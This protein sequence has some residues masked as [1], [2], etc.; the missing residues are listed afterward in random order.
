[1]IWAFIGGCVFGSVFTIFAMACGIAVGRA[2]KE[3]GDDKP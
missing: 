2:E 1:M 3:D